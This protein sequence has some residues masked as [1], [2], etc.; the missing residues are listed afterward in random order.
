M[1]IR[2]LLLLYFTGL[3]YFACDDDHQIEEND[4][5]IEYFSPYIGTYLYDDDDCSGAD[6][7]YATFNRNQITLFDYLG[8][9]CDDTV[10]CYSSVIY[11]IEQI[12]QDSFYILSNNET[13]ITDG[14]FSIDSDK[15]MTLAYSTERG[16]YKYTWQKF[17]DDIYSFSPSCFEEYEYTKD[18]ADMMI[19]AVSDD[20]DLLWENY[21]HGGIWDL[22]NSVIPLVDGG[23][24]AYG[25]FDGIEWGGCCYNLNWSIGN[26]AKLDN[27]GHLEWKKEIKFGEDGKSQ[28]YNDIGNS[29]IQTSNG[30]LVFLVPINGGGIN[31]VTMDNNGNLIWSQNF[32][33]MIAW[34]FN[35][36]IIEA[37]DG[38]IVL[39]SGKPSKLKIIDNS[40]GFLIKETQYEGLN[41][42]RTII[43]VEN[44]YINYGIAPKGENDDYDP[45]YLQRVSNDGTE[46]WRK[47]WSDDLVS[48]PRTAMDVLQ[49]T[50]DGFLLFCYSDP[51]PY[52]TLIKTD[53]DGNELWRKK[54]DDYIGN[55]KGWIHQTDDRGFLMVSGYAVTKLDQNCNIIWKASAPTGFDK[56][57]N[58]GMV[59]GINHSMSPIENGVV[60]SG[61]GSSDWE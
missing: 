58:N 41:Y 42:P 20:G 53:S 57:F 27:N 24:M 43:K 13:R 47:I 15:L 5:N 50:D 23:Y 32:P 51:S 46:I 35:A 7:Q 6:I 48:R 52:A 31:I 11:E 21:L 37:N 12:N 3:S 36:E 10:G 45:I 59:S 55:S 9:N 17:S 33:D 2:A 19:Y 38:N 49:T 26:I 28:W 18:I 39:V 40:S 30:N 54:F 29:L 56:Y 60:I 1:K 22:A 8:D 61:Y 34:N 25:I 44:G 16:N 4:N 14:V